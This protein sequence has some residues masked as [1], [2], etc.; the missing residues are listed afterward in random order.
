MTSTDSGQVTMSDYQR[1]VAN[2]WNTNTN[3]PVNLE[4][5]KVDDLY[6]HH[7]G[8]GDPDPA[9][10]QAPSDIRDE[11]IIKEL[12]RLESAQADI[13]LD[14]LGGISARLAGSWTPGPGEADRASWPT[15]ASAA[16][17]TA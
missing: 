13:L 4:L 6:H 7:Y 16:R 14:H 10:L 17:W 2:Y 5:G 8:L 15:P 3:D 12:H 1:A 11:V 9:V